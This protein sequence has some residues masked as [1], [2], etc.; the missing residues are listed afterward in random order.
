MTKFFAALCALAFTSCAVAAEVAKEAP[1]TATAKKSSTV[2][3]SLPTGADP[4][5]PVTPATPQAHK[6]E[7][8]TRETPA[9][10][11]K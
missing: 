8:K 9:V 10:S 7:H 4:T 2:T 3:K 6:K 1:A 5:P 11:A